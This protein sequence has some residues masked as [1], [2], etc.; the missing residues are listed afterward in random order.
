MALSR[1]LLATPT[2][3]YDVGG[4]QHVAVNCTIYASSRDLAA[5]QNVLSE[6]VKG[7][8]FVQALNRTGD[9]PPATLALA[10]AQLHRQPVVRG[11]TSAE[12]MSHAYLIWLRLSA[13][14]PVEKVEIVLFQQIAGPVAGPAPAPAPA[15]QLAQQIVGLPVTT[16]PAASA[17]VTAPSSPAPPGGPS[18]TV[19]IASSVSVAAAAGAES[20]HCT[21]K[22]CELL[23]LPMRTSHLQG[24]WSIV[25]MLVLMKISKPTLFTCFVS[26]ALL[27][28][29]AAIYV[30]LW[31]RR[32][33][34]AMDAAQKEQA[35]Q[36]KV[37]CRFALLCTCSA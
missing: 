36:E 14:L 8:D 26:A 2:I 28:A 31:R 37:W 3:S 13:G 27:A 11:P 4:A 6:S 9:S 5:I 15:P 1:V 18:K 23:L 35:D 17:P 21:S 10:S 20:M 30:T 32:R 7:G 29:G 24:G 34:A 12:Q 22:C 33:R 16:L 25:S 19:I